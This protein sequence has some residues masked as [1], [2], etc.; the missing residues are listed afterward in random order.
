MK[1]I[2]GP[3]LDLQDFF[4]RGLSFETF[5]SGFRDLLDKLFHM[6]EKTFSKKKSK[7]QVLFKSPYY[8]WM[9]TKIAFNSLF[10]FYYN[11]T[12]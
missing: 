12:K 10:S 6:I 4:N 5:N 2:A 3:F 8:W 1:A 11:M 9:K 7:F